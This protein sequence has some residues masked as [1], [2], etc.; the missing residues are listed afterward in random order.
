[1][2]AQEIM[3][4]VWEDAQCLHS[5]GPIRDE[6]VMGQ[7]IFH[8]S[9]D[10]TSLPGNKLVRLVITICHGN[11]EGQTVGRVSFL[12]VFLLFLPSFIMKAAV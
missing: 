5:L 12:C 2:S 7:V 6:Q 10:N 9:G 8:Q 3:G 11:E 4:Q 1:M